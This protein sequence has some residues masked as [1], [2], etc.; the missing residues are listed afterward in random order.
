MG[1]EHFICFHLK[2]IQ[3]QLQDHKAVVWPVEA[4]LLEDGSNVAIGFLDGHACSV[5]A[6]ATVPSKMTKFLTGSA[7]KTIKL[8]SHQYNEI[9]VF[10]GNFY[11]KKQQ[12]GHFPGHTDVV[13]ALLVLSEHHFLSTSNDASIILWDLNSGARLRNFLP[14]HENF[15]YT[16]VFNILNVSKNEYHQSDWRV[17]TSI[18]RRN[19]SFPRVR[20]DAWTFG[21]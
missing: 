13:R 16:F 20:V 4:L 18:L 17:L 10:H 1:K 8:W 15:I 2:T 21:S 14:Q 19:W 7:D 11:F 3:I 5:W 12:I 9:G 6:V